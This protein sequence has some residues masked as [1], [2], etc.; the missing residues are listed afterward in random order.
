M[1]LIKRKP[2]EL[3]L[4]PRE[5]DYDPQANVYY[6]KQTGEIFPDYE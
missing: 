3:V 4:P 6:I 5:E 2:V 1:P